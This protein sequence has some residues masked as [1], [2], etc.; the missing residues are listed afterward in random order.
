MERMES[1]TRSGS[2]STGLTRPNTRRRELAHEGLLW[3][4]L[5]QPANT[6]AAYLRER[7]KLDPLLLEDMLST[8]QRPRLDRHPTDEYLFLV[9]QVPILDRDN[10]VVMNEVDLFAGANFIVT[11]HDGNLKPLRRL[12]AAASTDES[13]RMQLLGRG[14][15]YLLY[16]ILDTLVKQSF[17]VVYRFDEELGKLESRLFAQNSRELAEGCV[18]LQRDIIALRYIIGPNVD[19]TAALRSLDA[20]FLRID[21]A[22]YFGDCAEGFA[23]LSDLV[24]EQYDLSRGLCAMLGTAAAQQQSRALQRLVVIGLALV[25]LVI[26]A[27][28]AALSL[29]APPLERPIVFAGVVLLAAAVVAGAIS[30]GRSKRWF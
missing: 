23:K 13:A 18:L 8:I 17:P 9:I 12:F 10:R 16:R 6:D 24:E 30:Y 26:L 25:P 22:R 29:V 2:T 4:D 7:L 3:L 15:G 20:A 5:P 27:A 11:A 28:L 1:R 19:A 21:A 14:P